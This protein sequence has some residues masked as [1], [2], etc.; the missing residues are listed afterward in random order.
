MPDTKVAIIT[1][2]SRGIGAACARELSERG[3]AVSLLSRSAECLTLAR[4]L[5]GI[6]RQGSVTDPQ[7]LEALVTSTLNHY[8]RIDAV[9]NNT[10]DPPQP[11]DHDLLRI[12]DEQ[13]HENLDLLLLNVARMARL[14]TPILIRQGGGAIVNI[15]AAD[16]YEPERQF[17][18]GSTLR[19]ALG[20]YTKL[21]A[22]QYADKGIRM[23]CVLPGITFDYDPDDVRED[24]R[25]SVPMRRPARYREIAKAVAF[26]LSEDASYVTGQNWR[27]DGGLTRSV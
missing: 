23:N 12:T 17:A 7:D 15:S 2:A 20:A 25:V 4:E 18:I 27:V 19:A 13:W 22:D 21:Y 26:L 9:V 10:G 5:G 24:I 16:A 6:A 14:V 1:A 11:P 8:G 3:Y